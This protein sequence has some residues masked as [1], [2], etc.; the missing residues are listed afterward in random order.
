MLRSAVEVCLYYVFVIFKKDQQKS[1]TSW[2][3]G[4]ARQIVVTKFRNKLNEFIMFRLIKSSKS[5][6]VYVQHTIRNAFKSSAIFSRRISHK[7]FKILMCTS[8]YEVI[9]LYKSESALKTPKSRGFVQYD[10]IT[11]EKVMAFGFSL[12][13][14]VNSK[15]NLLFLVN[16]KFW[17]IPSQVT[18]YKGCFIYSDSC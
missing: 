18:L 1:F 4:G 3:S 14:E 15:R 5:T 2:P 17:I 13:S 11:T 10:S 7:T 6:S 16:T 8:S 12:W 9:L